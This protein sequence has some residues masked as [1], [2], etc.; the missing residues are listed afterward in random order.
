VRLYIPE[1]VYLSVVCC[2]CISL[3]QI[4]LLVRNV[5]L[6][7]VCL[8]MFMI[9]VVSLPMYV[10]VAHFCFSIGLGSSG[11]LSFRLGGF[12]GQIG[13]ELLS[14]MLWMICSSCLYSSVGKSYVFSLLYKNLIASN[15][16]L[17]GIVRRVR[18]DRV[19]ECRLPVNGHLPVC[20]GSVNSY[21]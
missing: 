18:Y 4:V 11:F 3:F 13:N 20:K 6:M 9:N 17:G 16:M 2:L 5:V 19:G 7:L 12:C 21:V 15:F 10:N 8:K 14:R 1:S